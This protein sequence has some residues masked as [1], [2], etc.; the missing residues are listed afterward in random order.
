MLPHL[1][2]HNMNFL[3]NAQ[4]D[5]DRGLRYTRQRDSFIM[6]VYEALID[7]R[8]DR[9]MTRKDLVLGK[10]DPHLYNNVGHLEAVLGQVDVGAGGLASVSGLASIA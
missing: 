4:Y 5:K 7:P 2:A 9:K 3:T 6:S 8:G 10:A 1:T